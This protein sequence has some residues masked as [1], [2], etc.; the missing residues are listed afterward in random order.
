MVSP[1]SQIVVTGAGFSEPGDEG[2]ARP[3]LR[4]PKLRKLLG[5]WDHLAVLAASRAIEAA[6]LPKSLGERAGLYVVVGHVPAQKENMEALIEGSLDENGEFSGKLHARGG[7]LNF[8]PIWTFRSLTNA[9]AFFVSSCFDIQGPYFV[10]FSEPGQFY[11][12]LEEGI[13]ALRAGRADIAVVGATVDQDNEMVRFHYR[14][15]RPPVAED[16]LRS[17]AG[18]LVLETAEAA[19]ARGAQAH[20]VLKDY[21]IGYRTHDPLMESFAQEETFQ[22]AG[23][24]SDAFWGPAS[25]PISIARAEPGTLQHQLLSRDG[26]QATSCW[27]VQQ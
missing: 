27:E 14:R 19:S 22:P 23:P 4:T 25:L 18:F 5:P 17:G 2:D 12:A 16:L 26:I 6:G 13:H 10:T 9:P 8:N 24:C 11:L 20:A 7:Y 1:D 3:F 21:T 15:T